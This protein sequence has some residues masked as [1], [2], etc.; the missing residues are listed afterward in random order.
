MLKR[1]GIIIAV[2]FCWFFQNAHAQEWEQPD[3]NEP[4]A[5]NFFG[6]SARAMGMGGAYIAV[7]ND[8]TALVYNPAGLAQVKRIEFSGGLS[9]QR[10]RNK[11]GS[12]EFTTP[13]F[14]HSFLQTNTRFSSANIVLPVPTYR[15]SL[16][17]ALGVNRIGSFDR[18]LQ[19]VNLEKNDSV[20]ISESGG[21]YA[22][23]FGGGIDLSPQV[24]VGAALNFWSGKYDYALLAD[25]TYD[26]GTESWRYRW[27]DAITDRY[28]GFNV[29]LGTR[30]QPNKFLV[31][32]GTIETPVTYTIKEEWL[33]LTDTVFY[34]PSYDWKE[35]P[36]I[37]GNSE[38]KFTLPFILGFG[39]A[40][41]VKNV[42]LAADLNY[43]GWTEIEYKRFFPRSSANRVI[44]EVYKEV[45]R[46]HIGAEYTIA[47]IG[48]SLR[49]GYFQ[50]PFPFKSP[51]IKSD[52]HYFTGGFGILID[53]VTTID[54][55]LVHGNW[56]INDFSKDLASKYI[57][58]QI[59]VSVAYRL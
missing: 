47:Q 12:L 59:F 22:W 3:V 35:Y 23:S 50:N 29:K 41:N 1:M 14:N 11:T 20:T 26:E 44:R 15:G 58:N 13:H 19:Y 18:T 51:W 34:R 9:H 45:L 49:A 39:T 52:R 24:S 21:L 8:A 32:G 38:Y 31:I 40:I 16:V 43:A 30:I 53:Q 36:P 7:A 55:A 27:D 56:E 10:L 46:W 57:T 37:E 28:S 17:L 4:S 6:V 33:Q 5:G 54:V 42:I 2:L 48:T 25:S